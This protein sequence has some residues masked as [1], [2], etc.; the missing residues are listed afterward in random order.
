MASIEVF[1]PQMGEGVIE[2]VIT[3]WFVEIN[4]KVSVDE[5]L[6][7][8][9]TDKVDS[10]VPAPADG[11]LVKK[12]FSVGEIPK[13]GDVIAVIQSNGSSGNTITDT[14]QE[15]IL[16]SI[17]EPRGMN[18]AV[19]ID[20]M[21]RAEPKDVDLSYQPAELPLDDN[22]II[23]PFIRH[24]AVMRGITPD[25]LSTLVGSGENG[26]ITKNDIL[27]YFKSGKRM[28]PLNNTIPALN[29]K[30]QE[31]E[32]PQYTPTDGEEV[33]ELDRMRKIIAE[34]MVQSVKTAPHVTSFLDV[35]IT[36]LVQWREKNK[37]TFI[38]QYGVNLTYTPVITE[39]VVQALK[40][41]P[42]INVSLYGDKLIR[43]K[44][45]N[46][47]IATALPNGNLIVPVIKGADK[48][49]LPKLAQD[50][51]DLANKARSGGLNPGDTQGGTFTITNL[52]QFDTVTGTPIINQPESAILAVGSI[53]KR[54]WVVET[55]SMQTI[56]IRDVVTLAL[57]Y[58][59]RIIDGALG[60][61]FLSRIGY[62]LSNFQ[63]QV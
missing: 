27:N 56:G 5:P 24:F 12:F 42:G 30:I 46:V 52:G 14:Q 11:V 7:E 55:E 15:E 33:V 20:T 63:P 8:I 49:N 3:R 38:E 45:I 17:G 60:G 57:S 4:S 1:L 6:V 29:H 16:P 23:S 47:G 10:E 28:Q 44:Y 59:H 25:E 62:L 34:R 13:V 32:L 9:A 2:A 39:V 21:Y 37:K 40:E 18:G 53:K 61:A 31:V 50:I 19:S 51:R 26:E 58:D 35:D 43:K 36:A 54:P 41:F 22:K 48:I